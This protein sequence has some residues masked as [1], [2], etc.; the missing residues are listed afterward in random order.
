MTE[1]KIVVEDGIIAKVFA[2]DPG[3]QVDV[4]DRDVNDIEDEEIEQLTDNHYE[5]Y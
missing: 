3:I 4:I 2:S 1:I 5:V